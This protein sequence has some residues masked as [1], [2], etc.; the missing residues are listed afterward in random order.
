[1]S[2][3]WA[4]AM[5]SRANWLTAGGEVRS[6]SPATSRVGTFTLSRLT[7]RVMGREPMA[8]PITASTRESASSGQHRVG[9]GCDGGRQLVVVGLSGAPW[10][11]AA[12]GGERGDGSA[13]SAL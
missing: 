11:A 12:G 2:S 10:C 1:M 8:R 6:S 7:P 13:G 3:F 4:L 9:A 5:L